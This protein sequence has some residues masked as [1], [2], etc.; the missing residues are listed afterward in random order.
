LRG[1]D[2]GWDRRALLTLLGAAAAAWPV[3][4]R[5]QQGE[6]IRRVGF[7]HGGSET[8][9]SIEIFVP[10]FAQGLGELGWVDGGN[11]RIEHRWAEGNVE[12]MRMLA[13]ELVDL[14]PDVICVTSGPAAKALQEQTRSIPI[15]L[16]YAGDPI[17]NGL[18]SNAAR[19]GGNITGVTNLFP[20]LGG[21]WL[22]LLKE[23]KPSLARVALVFNPEFLNEAT[24]A[25][26]ESAAAKS[27]VKAVR[28]AVRDRAGIAPALD[29][30]AAEPDGGIIPVA[31]IGAMQGA[32]AL[33]DQLALRHRLPVIEG[34]RS[35]ASVSLMTYGAVA[36]DM[37]RRGAPD[38]VNRILRGAKPGELPI[39]YPTKFELVINLKIAKAIGLELPP[40]LLARADEVIE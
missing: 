15:V 33:I 21:K 36:A 34:D 30:F 11:L 7:L 1:N 23:A 12:R 3:G 27:G 22:D 4:A 10:A 2:R 16:V 19:P 35:F 8:G 13:R 32:T 37:F 18:V 39:Q 20:S 40:L 31:P 28:I 26:I 14:A 25:A 38:Y 5:A 17:S 24:M 9:D 29:A 6:R